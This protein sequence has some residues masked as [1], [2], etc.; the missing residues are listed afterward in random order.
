M[1]MKKNHNNR[2]IK[3]ICFTIKKI[4]N[5]S[6]N[7]HFRISTYMRNACGDFD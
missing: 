7:I 4:K 5:K 1:C 2:H 6:S 3:R